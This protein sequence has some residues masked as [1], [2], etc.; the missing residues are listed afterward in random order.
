ML[1]AD[2]YHEL[3]RYASIRGTDADTIRDLYLSDVGLD[4]Q[5][6]KVYDL[7]N[8]TVTVRLQ[9]DLSF[10]VELP[11]GKTAK[12]LPKKNADPDKYNAANADFSEMKKSVKKIVKNRVTLLFEDFLSGS[13][14]K[15]DAWQNAYL[16]NV[17]LRSVANLLV[18]SQGKHTFIVSEN[19]PVTVTGDAYAIRSSQKI[20]VA[21]PMEMTPDEVTAW[22]KYF[23]A[24]GLKQP[25]E[26]IWEPVIDGTTVANDRYKDCRIPYYR[27]TGQQKH[28]IAVED[29][30]FHNEIEIFFAECD[31]DIERLD[32]ERHNISPDHCFEVTSFKFDKYTRQVNHIVAYLDRVTIY[33]RIRKDDADIVRYLPR[34]T[35]A[36]ITEF[37]R[38]AG[39]SNSSNAM[40]VLLEYKNNTFADFDPME[41]FSLDW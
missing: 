26:Q 22:Q 8:Q 29:Y 11:T 6:G 32:W 34:F 40:A 14:R 24:R 38:I 28:G 1:F 25:F 37:I 27:F 36:Q 10:L 9:S 3:N 18:W 30:D 7:G 41:E 16:S 4:A 33:D 5:G 39:E 23:T 19:G 21:H 17:L 15:A 31:A 12:S 2:K 35:L 13:A 20:A